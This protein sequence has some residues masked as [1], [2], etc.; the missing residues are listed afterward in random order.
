MARPLSGMR[1]SPWSVGSVPLRIDAPAQSL[2]HGGDG[3]AHTA[4]YSLGGDHADPSGASV[5]RKFS[6]I[7]AGKS[8]PR[9]VSSDHDPLFYS[10]RWLANL[11]ILEIE[12]IKRSRMYRVPSV[13]RTTDWD[14]STRGSRP[15]TVSAAEAGWSDTLQRTDRNQLAQNPLADRGRAKQPS[16]VMR[17]QAI[18]GR[19]AC[20]CQG[21]WPDQPRRRRS[22]YQG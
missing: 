19:S 17:S 3:R 8:L 14:D 18:D 9:H 16:M 5:C 7:I 15:R 11:R 12:E 4:D 21:N 10:H 6:S 22:G 2:R 20:T 13:R 1:R